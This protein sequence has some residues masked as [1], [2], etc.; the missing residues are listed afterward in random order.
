MVHRVLSQ[1]SKRQLSPSPRRDQDGC[2]RRLAILSPPVAAS[3]EDAG[4]GEAVS[5]EEVAEAVPSE[6]SEGVEIFVKKTFFF[7]CLFECP[8]FSFFFFLRFQCIY[9]SSQA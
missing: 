1:K 9:I 3:T 5:A 8:S 7:F 6:A 4:H 2:W